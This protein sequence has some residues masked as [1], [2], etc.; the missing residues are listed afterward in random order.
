MWNV[1]AVS[2]ADYYPAIWSTEKSTGTLRKYRMD[3]PPMYPRDQLSAIDD[4]NG[5]F[6]EIHVNARRIRW[7]RSRDERDLPIRI[8]QARANPELD[9]ASP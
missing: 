5:R 8:M 2:H 6:M 9:P 7:I 3:L 4:S 1:T